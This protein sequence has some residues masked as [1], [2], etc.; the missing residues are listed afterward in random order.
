MR[1]HA[2]V[3][4][5]DQDKSLAVEVECMKFSSDEI[6]STA[7]SP[8]ERKYKLKPLTEQLQVSKPE[9]LSKW[10]AL[11]RGTTLRQ[12]LRVNFPRAV[13]LADYANMSVEKRGGC[14]STLQCRTWGSLCSRGLQQLTA[15]GHPP[16]APFPAGTSRE[17]GLRPRS[18]T[19]LEP[20][21]DGVSPR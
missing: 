9:T 20:Q 8:A 1:V 19:L 18:R 15:R 10:A 13:I 16:R 11:G 17:D 12:V 6:L 5:K 2:L 14:R 7:G 21:G 3:S 4:R